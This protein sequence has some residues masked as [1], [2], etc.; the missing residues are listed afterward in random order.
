MDILP[1]IVNAYNYTVHRSIKMALA[2]VTIEDE[3]TIYFNL[4]GD[5]ENV[6]IKSKLN[7]GDDVILRYELDPFD[8]SYY[9]LWTNRVYKISRSFEKYNKPLY[10][11][12]DGDSELKRRFYPEEL[13]KVSIDTNTRWLIDRI[14]E[15]RTVNGEKKTLIKWKGYPESHNQWIP[16][17]QIEKL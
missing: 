6:P 4:Y 17:T 9:P 8:K 12:H 5:G 14:V 3:P 1:Q 15:Y 11:L 7:I 2:D 10:T 13:Q 16:V